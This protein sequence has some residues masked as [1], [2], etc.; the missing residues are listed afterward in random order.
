ML[1]Y[2]IDV[3][4]VFGIH[5]SLAGPKSFYTSDAA[6]P[7]CARTGVRRQRWDVR[8]L[9]PKAG[10]ILVRNLPMLAKFEHVEGYFR[11]YG[12][13]EKVHF[14]H[15]KDILYGLCCVVTMASMR[16]ARQILNQAQHTIMGV[17]V[18]V[19]KYYGKRNHREVYSRG[20][21]TMTVGP[22]D[23]P[24][25]RDAI[26]YLESLFSPCRH[27][28]SIQLLRNNEALIGPYRSAKTRF[29]SGAARRRAFWFKDLE[30]GYHTY[31]HSE[32]KVAIQSDNSSYRRY[33]IHDDMEK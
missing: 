4:L 10:Q 7:K 29:R 22:L 3:T 27:Y 25:G 5:N 19:E 23:F 1:F 26:W 21:H 32:K 12:D 31:I 14:K 2:P 20:P 17:R 33:L 18:E 11:N 9:R 6:I 13:V 16:Q 30:K 8:K 24:G 15:R 28:S